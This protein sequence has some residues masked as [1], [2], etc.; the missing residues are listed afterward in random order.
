M[1]TEQF[2]SKLHIYLP[3]IHHAT[4]NTTDA[5]ITTIVITSDPVYI[6]ILLTY[7]WFI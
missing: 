1:T 5:F 6:V 7:L 3:K 4:P 2:L